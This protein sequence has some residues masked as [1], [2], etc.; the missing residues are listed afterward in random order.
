MCVSARTDE[1]RVVKLAKASSL[2]EQY[3]GFIVS[4]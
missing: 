1:L 4:A 2:F 3:D